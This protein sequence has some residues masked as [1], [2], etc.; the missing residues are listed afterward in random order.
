MLHLYFMKQRQIKSTM[1]NFLP[2]LHKNN[3]YKKCAYM[4]EYQQRGLC[5]YY[6]YYYDD[7]GYNLPL[8]SY[9]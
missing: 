9:V 1:C 4:Y 5:P 7:D 6:C 2:S 8:L 3:T